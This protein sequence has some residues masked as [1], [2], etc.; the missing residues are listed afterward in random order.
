MRP[1]GLMGLMGPIGPMRLMGPMGLIGLIGLMGSCSGSE[2]LLPQVH[3]QEQGSS[4]F[5]IQTSRTPLVE[6]D[7]AQSRESV[8]GSTVLTRTWT[9]PTG[10]STYGDLTE[11]FV[12][13]P[14]GMDGASIG[15][16]LTQ[17][18]GVPELGTFYKD[19]SD[20]KYTDDIEAGTYYLY[21]YVPQTAADGATITGN[22]NYS[23]GAVLTISGLHT[24]SL[25]D[26]CV[27]VGAKA[28]T[29]DDTDGGLVQGRFD[30]EAQSTDGGHN[31]IFM[32][33]DHLYAMLRISFKV[34]ATYKA[35]RTIK[36]RTLALRA[37]DADGNAA[38][39]KYNA[40]VTLSKT[41]DGTTPISSVEFTPDE[42]SSNSELVTL[43]SSAAGVELSSGGVTSFMGCFVPQGS[44][45]FVM[46]TTYDVY[47]T[48]NNLIREGCKASNTISLF[49]IFAVTSL[50]RGHI[51]S[52]TVTVKP[53]Y[54]YMLSEPDLDNPTM[55]IE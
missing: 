27:T 3:E 24:V 53:T 33:F 52:M 54:L 4:G 22:E 15:V 41:D 26:A 30:V 35:L 49:P 50:Q 37:V 12:N 55:E 45:H 20:W 39:A 46:Q 9:P 28:G 5:V 29:D 25:D 17:N 31:Y 44:S 18:G 43:Y 2:E 51:Y 47:D 14:T 11:D 38:K 23:D 36:I 1:I 34:D 21:G 16:F 10:F 32:L 8:Q 48:K 13:W 7:D 6:E 40:V 19:D 42:S